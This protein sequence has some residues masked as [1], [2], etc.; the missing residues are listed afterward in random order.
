VL[1]LTLLA[2]LAFII[3]FAVF[4][5]AGQDSM[6][7][8]PREYP[9][10]DLASFEAA[11]GRRLEFKTHD[12]AQTAFFYWPSEGE[13]SE[14]LPR[15]Y[16]L[17]FGGNGAL[18]LD[19]ISLIEGNDEPGTAFLLIDY[20]SYGL[21]EGKPSRRSIDANIDGAL[22]ACAQQLGIAKETIEAN[23]SVLGHSL[24]AA[25]A[26]MAAEKCGAREII[27]VSPF[28]SLKELAKHYFPSPM[29]LL[30]RHRFDNRKALQKASE[31]AGT[32]VTVFHGVND[33]IIPASMSRRLATEFPDLISLRE[34]PGAGHND[35][36]Y[37]IQ[38]QL[39]ARLESPSDR[40]DR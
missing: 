12:G 20:P 3:I 38:S 24:G 2:F 30:L 31:V 25:V 15:R 18:A 34:I 1:A 21:C 35:I 32:T 39:E 9:E 22:A 17:L 10:S 14:E 4:T 5:Y 11:G 7:F 29:T 40:A 37:R 8:M 19:W 16:W 27:L 23:S 26:L 13:A 36:I 6:I 28:T 33:E